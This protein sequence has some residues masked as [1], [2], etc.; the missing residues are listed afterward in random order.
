MIDVK[1]MS[2]ADIGESFT[3]ID[4]DRT[5]LVHGFLGMVGESPTF[6]SW[7]SA[8]VEWIAGYRRIKPAATDD[9]CNTAWSRFVGALRQYAGEAGFECTI[10]T[11]PKS[12]NPESVK[13]AESRANP[14]EGQTLDQVRE[15]QKAI[16]AK[17]S[18][19]QKEGKIPEQQILTDMAKA[20]EQVVKLER[21][22]GKLRVKANK[23]KL[24]PRVDA[25]KKRIAQCDERFIALVEALADA[26]DLRNPESVRL[27]S[28]DVLKKA[29]PSTEAKASQRRAA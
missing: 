20:T 8:R 26:T 23:E 6:E 15:A 19:A 9:A 22:E 24:A 11:K 3:R 5:L 13:K 27:A 17:V 10:P 4:A 29:M 2:F 25:L 14:F 7:E 12:T 16:V 28:W 1:S 21:E 18:E